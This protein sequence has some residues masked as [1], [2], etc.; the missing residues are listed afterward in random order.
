MLKINFKVVRNGLTLIDANYGEFINFSDVANAISNDVDKLSNSKE[1]YFSQF[2]KKMN[3]KEVEY[4][5]A[6][7]CDW[8]SIDEII[9][10]GCFEMWEFGKSCFNSV[11]WKIVAKTSDN[12]A[13]K[14]KAL[15]MP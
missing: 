1:G 11:C 4:K 6:W 3:E 12:M 5:F 10:Y 2:N 9:D 15:K 14:E 7:N 13:D 8:N